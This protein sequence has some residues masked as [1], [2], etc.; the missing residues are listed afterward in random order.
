MTLEECVDLGA[1]R[2]VID[3]SGAADRYR[4]Y[5]GGI[6]RLCA[7]RCMRRFANRTVVA[8]SCICAWLRGS[9]K[10]KA[11]GFS[12]G[13]GAGFDPPGLTLAVK[14]F[15][16]FTPRHAGGDLSDERHSESEASCVRLGGDTASQAC[17]RASCGI[18]QHAAAHC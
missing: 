14:L 5:G 9:R 18:S 8:R 6:G 16:R 11:L 1:G 3:V 12:Y 4:Y 13:S 2:E 10:L 7:C 17:A 15:I